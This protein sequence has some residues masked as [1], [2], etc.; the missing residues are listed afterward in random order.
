MSKRDFARFEFRRDILCYN[1]PWIWIYPMLPA[2][3]WRHQMKSF[4]A[5]WALCEGNT[6]ATGVFASQ[7]PVTRSS[8]VLFDLRLNKRLSNQSRWLRWFEMT[9]RSL[10]RNCNES[11]SIS[12]L[13]HYSTFRSKLLLVVLKLVLWNVVVENDPLK[14]MWHMHSKSLTGYGSRNNVKCIYSYSTGK[15]PRQCSIHGFSLAGVSNH[16]QCTHSDW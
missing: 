14:C 11:H 1:N 10:W 12:L 4:S 13:A 6:P 7:R 3:L 15:C 5:L 8:D 16:V 2:T 9:S